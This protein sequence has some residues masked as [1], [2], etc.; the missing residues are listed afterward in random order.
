MDYRR[1]T[2]LRRT[3]ACAALAISLGPALAGCVSQSERPDDRPTIYYDLGQ[4][5]TTTKRQV[6]FYGCR[7]G[8]MVCSG[9]ASYVD[10]KYQCRCE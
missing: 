7:T 9:P 8:S 5:W 3:A 1:S 10:T 4:A 6:R 2:I